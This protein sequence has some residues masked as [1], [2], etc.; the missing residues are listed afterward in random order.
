MLLF[1]EIIFSSQFYYFY[2]NS[3]EYLI[4]EFFFRCI[5]RKSTII[6]LKVISIILIIIYACTG[7]FFR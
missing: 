2:Q 6:Q 3:F 5:E 4:C 1:L 7:C